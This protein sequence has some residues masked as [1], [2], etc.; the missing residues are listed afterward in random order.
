MRIKRSRPQSRPLK[1]LSITL[2]V[3]VAAALPPSAAAELG[4]N[5]ASIAQDQAHMQAKL[6]VARAGMYTLHEMRAATGTV[7]REYVSSAG[8]VFAVAWQGPWIPDMRQLLGPYFEQYSRAAKAPRSGHGPLLISEPGLMVQL[9]GHQRSFAGRA[10]LPQMVPV[11][12]AVES[13]R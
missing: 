8:T 3:V 4:G 6:K 9:S 1:A 2:L 11:G 5:V 7:V 10:L 13:L 12:V